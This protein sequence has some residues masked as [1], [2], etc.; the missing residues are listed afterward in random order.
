M[1]NKNE[2][3][4]NPDFV[5]KTMRRVYAYE[6][7]RKTFPIRAWMYNVLQRYFLA[8]GGAL[9]GILNATRVF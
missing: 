5:P 9:F 2:Y 6:A 7:S 3:Q 8:F 1:N 4:P